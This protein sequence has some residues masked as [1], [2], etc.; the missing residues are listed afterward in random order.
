MQL[1]DRRQGHLQ[2]FLMFPGSI[3]FWQLFDVL[4]CISVTSFDFW[5]PQASAPSSHGSDASEPTVFCMH[6]LFMVMS[7]AF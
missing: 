6:A 2:W 1:G 3:F 5:F 4:I 7:Y